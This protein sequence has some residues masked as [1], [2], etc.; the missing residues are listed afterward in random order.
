ML[1]SGASGYV[2]CITEI[3]AYKLR[4]PVLCQIEL[5]DGIV[6]AGNLPVP[7]DSDVEVLV[8]MCSHFLGAPQ[9]EKVTQIF[10][11][12]LQDFALPDDVTPFT[13]Q[14]REPAPVGLSSRMKRLA[15]RV[16][17]R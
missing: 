15:N 5:V 16:N 3:F 2:P 9:S 7:P 13:R 14:H 11:L 6:L 4:P 17:S 12:Y 1:A 10:G 8:E